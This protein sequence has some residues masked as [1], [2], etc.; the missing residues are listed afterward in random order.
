METKLFQKFNESFKPMERQ[1]REEELLIVLDKNAN[2]KF[3]RETFRELIQRVRDKSL[4]LTPYNFAGVYYEAHEVLRL[5]I[6]H[7]MADLNNIDKS[8]KLIKQTQ[9]KVISVQ[10]RGL[11]LENPSNYTNYLTFDL[12]K[13]FSLNFHHFDDETDYIY[14][15][16]ELLKDTEEI[17][18]TLASTSLKVIDTKKIESKPLTFEKNIGLDF[19]DGS[20]LECQISKT[21]ISKTLCLEILQKRKAELEEYGVHSITKRSHLVEAFPTVF[22]NSVNLNDQKMT[23]SW[24]FVVSSILTGIMLVIS[25]FLNSTRCMFIDIFVAISFFGNMYVWRN[26]NVFLA[27]KLIAV[28][29][30]SIV[31][32][33]AWE[34]I[35]LINYNEKYEGTVKT[36]RITG[37]LLTAA[38]VL[39]KL[40]LLYLY[41]RL[42]KEDH[43]NGYLGL[44]DELS[45][46]E[47]GE[48]QYTTNARMSI[49]PYT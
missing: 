48:D 28:L 5:K 49:S 20:K 30:I 31:L 3:N 25:L 22:S 39:V 19:S 1:V 46:D 37:F 7:T 45:M 11:K 16:E 9:D 41:F 18:V 26:F 36:L 21:E 23:C 2:K 35:K 42:S 10:I 32:D 40:A 27:V 47:V 38:G 34:I 29:G 4:D 44:N 13:N 14:I 17:Q 12:A 24:I 8:V 6:E 15:P 43:L 33:L